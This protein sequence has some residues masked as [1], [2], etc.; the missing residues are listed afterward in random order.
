[1]AA[2]PGDIIRT[3]SPESHAKL[4]EMSRLLKTAGIPKKKRTP[5]AWVKAHRLTV[6]AMALLAVSMGA[7]GYASLTILVPHVPAH[8][9]LYNCQSIVPLKTSVVINTTGFNLVTCNGNGVFHVLAG[10]NATANYTL[11]S[12]YLDLYVYPAGQDSVITTKCTDAPA[13]LNLAFPI[14]FGYSGN[15]SF[16]ADYGPVGMNGLPEFYVGWTVS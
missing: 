15:W 8:G 5:K 12:P 16:C 2:R 7:Y 6:L 3:W 10:T 1:M 9:I 14:I 11:P 13:A 4:M